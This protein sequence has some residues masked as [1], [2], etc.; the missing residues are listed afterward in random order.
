[1]SKNTIEIEKPKFP[2]IRYRVNNERNVTIDL[3]GIR[4]PYNPFNGRVNPSKGSQKMYLTPEHLQC[5]VDE[6]WES[7]MG[8]V[9]DRYGN[10]VKDEQ[11]RIVKTQ[12]KPFTLSGLALKLGVSTQTLKRYREGKL[13][14]LLDEMKAET[15]D[16]LTFSRV[17]LR[18]KQV[19]ESYAEGRLYDRDGSNGAKYVLD[20]VFGW[21]DRQTK[22]NIKRAKE[23]LQLKRD[24][25][26]LKRKL[27]DDEDEDDSITINVV[28]GKRDGTE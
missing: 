28:R 14:T 18:A 9:F 17:V 16:H 22:S 11:G 4:D 15:E 21:A 26:E 24:T 2:V 20:C 8:P 7:C 12:A 19:I 27:L 5:M 1:M 6:Y 23:E 25:F 3:R 13:D 10:L